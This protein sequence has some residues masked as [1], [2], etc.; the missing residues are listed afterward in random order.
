MAC[1]YFL[2][3]QQEQM[4]MPDVSSIGNG[5][6]GP[7]GRST[8]SPSLRSDA[9]HR[10]PGRTHNTTNDRVE[11]SEHARLLDRLRQ[12]PDVRTDR[13]AEIREQIESGRYETEERLTVA[14]D[15]LI[16]DLS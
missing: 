15:R 14:I 3:H 6:V 2:P 16:D 4:S 12:V 9:T 5:A 13:V 7:I 10:A 8:P 1:V 11:L